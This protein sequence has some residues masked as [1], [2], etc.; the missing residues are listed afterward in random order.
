MDDEYPLPP[1]DAAALLTKLGL[2]TTKATLAKKRCTGGGPVYQKYGPH[3]RYLPSRL[4][5]YRDSKV[6]GE[7]RSTSDAA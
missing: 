5:E 4:R 1:D 7:R 2:P 6:S 3:V